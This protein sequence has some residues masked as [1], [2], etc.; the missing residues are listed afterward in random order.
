MKKLCAL[1]LVF[2]LFTCLAAAEDANLADWVKQYNEEA[3]KHSA[4]LLDDS[5]FETV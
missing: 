1:A 5:A 4:T 2:A 3:A